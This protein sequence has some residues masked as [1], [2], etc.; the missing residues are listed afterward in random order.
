MRFQYR[1]LLLVPPQWYL[2]VFVSIFFFLC[3]LLPLFT[4][5]FFYFFYL[6]L[7]PSFFFPRLLYIS[8]FILTRF[9][10]CL[11]NSHPHEFFLLKLS[12][13]L[14][15]Y[16][17]FLPLSLLFFPPQIPPVYVSLFYTTVFLSILFVASFLSDD[18]HSLFFSSFMFLPLL[19]LPI[20][21][22][23]FTFHSASEFC[24]VPLLSV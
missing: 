6:Y 17:Y 2:P 20:F 3:I 5:P 9:I 23:L 13:L 7:Y 19:F 4:P 16:V 24:V 8:S 10:S 14:S 11:L 21:L 15:L 1:T 18:F 12:V 22:S